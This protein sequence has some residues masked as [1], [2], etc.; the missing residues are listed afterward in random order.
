MVRSTC[1]APSPQSCDV[2][3]YQLGLRLGLNAILE[4]G[5]RLGFRE[6]TG[7]DLQYEQTPI[8]PA[9]RAYYDRRYGPRGWAEGSTAI[10]LSIGQGENDQTPIIDD[11]VL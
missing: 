11:H 4:E 2:Y 3:F 10:N 7:V 9:S 5:V 8:F 1:W 6:R